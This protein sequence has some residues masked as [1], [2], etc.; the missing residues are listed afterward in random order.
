MKKIIIA[1]A[2]LAATLGAKAQQST[3]T[4]EPGITPSL[5]PLD[6]VFDGN[7]SASCAPTIT[8]IPYTFTLS[9]SPV[10]LTASPVSGIGGPPVSWIGGTSANY[11]NRVTFTYGSGAS[12]ISL[13]INMCTL[14][15]GRSTLL[16]SDGITPLIVDNFSD[17]TQYRINIHQ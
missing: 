11:F 15:P 13:T 1:C 3:F 12:M 17:P 7:V 10:I 8:S 4:I 5:L 16:F 14:P 6:F 2:L 9:A